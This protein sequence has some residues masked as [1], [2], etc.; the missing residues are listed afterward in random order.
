M[1]EWRNVFLISAAI[2]VVSGTIFIIF[3]SG[4]VQKWNDVKPKADP[5]TTTN[6]G[7]NEACC[8]SKRK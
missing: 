5:P 4:K 2:Y 8:E 1:Y 7:H 3:G 6:S